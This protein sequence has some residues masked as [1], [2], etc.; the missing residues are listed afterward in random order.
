MANEELLITLKGRVDYISDVE[1][2]KKGTKSMS[3]TLYSIVS[4]VPSLFKIKFWKDRIE[5]V[6]NMKLGSQVEL[7]VRVSVWNNSLE[8]SAV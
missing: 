5:N 6:R 4:G 7:P 8:I 3:V 2:T 1:I